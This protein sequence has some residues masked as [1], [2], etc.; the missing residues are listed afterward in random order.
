MEDSLTLADPWK[1]PEASKKL[2][3]EQPDLVRKM[4]T[5]PRFNIKTRKRHIPPAYDYVPADVIQ[6]QENISQLEYQGDA[7]LAA[8]PDNYTAVYLEDNGADWVDK[9]TGISDAEQLAEQDSYFVSYIYEAENQYEK[10]L[11]HKKQE[12]IATDSRLIY[13]N[14]ELTEHKNQNSFQKRSGNNLL[15]MTVIFPQEMFFPDEE[16][17]QERLSRVCGRPF[18]SRRHRRL[19]NGRTSVQGQWPWMG[20]VAESTNLLSKSWLTYHGCGGV[21]IS[22]KFVATASHCWKHMKN[23]EFNTRLHVQFG[24]TEFYDPSNEKNHSDRYQVLRMYTHSGFDI[25]SYRNDI[26]LLELKSPVNFTYKVLPV[27]LPSPGQNFVG[28]MAIVIGWGQLNYESARVSRVQQYVD[29]PIISRD[30]CQ[31]WLDISPENATV[32]P[33]HMCAGYVDGGKDACKGDSGGPLVV[34]DRDSK[35]VLAGTVSHGFGCAEPFKPGLYTNVTH[36]LPWILNI[37]DRN[38]SSSEA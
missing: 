13:F 28:E 20:Y 6:V 10:F 27:C 11:A 5:S 16:T 21:L 32:L 12:E 4:L 18:F 1:L 3:A 2:I 35:W 37:V 33:G 14:T 30:T 17:P 29:V 26:T 22:E 31:R 8:P 38:N 25:K 7:S 19:V 9:V 23:D 24:T 36:F 34:R 15:E